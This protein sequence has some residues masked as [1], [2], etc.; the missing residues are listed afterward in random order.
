MIF[1][2]DLVKKYSRSQYLHLLIWN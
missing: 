2:I 1:T